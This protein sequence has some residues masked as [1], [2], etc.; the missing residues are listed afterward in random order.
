VC[1]LAPHAADQLIHHAL[2]IAL[3]RP[4]SL[5]RSALMVLR[6]ACSRV[7][8]LNLHVRVALAFAITLQ[9]KAAYDE[10]EQA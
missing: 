5:L 8:L 6:R 2:P 9:Q 3:W 4:A 1:Q 7:C 10:L